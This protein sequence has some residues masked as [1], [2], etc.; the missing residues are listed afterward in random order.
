MRCYASQTRNK[1]ENQSKR[2]VWEWEHVKDK[3]EDFEK[4]ER[5]QRNKIEKQTGMKT[6]WWMMGYANAKERW[7]LFLSF[8]DWDSFR[9]LSLF[10]LMDCEMLFE[11]K[12]FKR[13]P[14]KYLRNRS[15]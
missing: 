15:I 10:F 13:K 1:T 11:M 2:R 3:K 12:R 6:G 5:L 14:E 4:K 9:S 7:T 8:V